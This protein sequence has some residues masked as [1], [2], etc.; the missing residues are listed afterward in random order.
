MKI[1]T[2]KSLAAEVPARWAARYS[3]TTSPNLAAI[4][5]KLAELPIPVDPDAVDSIV[6]NKSW[7]GIGICGECKKDGP[8]MLVQIGDEPDYDS[9]TAY[10]CLDCIGAAYRMLLTYHESR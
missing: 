7:T 10:V 3:G 5:K 9:H 6:G 4:T 2:R 1:L 8:P